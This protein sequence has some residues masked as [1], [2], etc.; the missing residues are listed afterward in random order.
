MFFNCDLKFVEIIV[1]TRIEKEQKIVDGKKTDF[2]VKAI[3]FVTNNKITVVAQNIEAANSIY[4][5]LNWCVGTSRLDGGQHKLGFSIKK[6]QGFLKTQTNR[7][8]IAGDLAQ[9]FDHL[10][11][12]FMSMAL[13][14]D[15]MKIVNPI[16]LTAEIEEKSNNK[17]TYVSHNRL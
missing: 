6:I 15:A 1:L 11:I 3:N 14:D 8:E 4:K 9:A 5:L 7:L 10:K 12:N 2:D 17:E 16:T 13:Y